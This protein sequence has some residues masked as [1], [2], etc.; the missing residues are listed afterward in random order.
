[1][2]DSPTYD[3]VRMVS[4]TITEMKNSEKERRDVAHLV[5]CRH[6]CGVF[7]GYA[8]KRKGMPISKAPTYM[9][10]RVPEVESNAAGIQRSP[11][12]R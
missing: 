12:R 2:R 3:V 4:P 10:A 6:I 9:L 5:D 11:A 8:E 7:E 1:M